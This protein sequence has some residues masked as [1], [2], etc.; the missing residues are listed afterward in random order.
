MKK[1]FIGNV[2]SSSAWK[3]FGQQNRLKTAFKTTVKVCC[4]FKKKFVSKFSANGENGIN[5]KIQPLTNGNHTAEIEPEEPQETKNGGT[6]LFKV[7][8]FCQ[9]HRI[10][11]FD[12]KKFNIYFFNFS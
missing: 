5:H 2:A 6:D 3:I 7:L 10:F 8:K 1:E 12:G 4:D 9:I 11:Y